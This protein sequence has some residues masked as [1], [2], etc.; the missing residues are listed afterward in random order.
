MAR[1]AREK[2]SKKF[3]WNF[4]IRLFLETCCELAV[5]A[6]LGMSYVDLEVEEGGSLAVGQVFNAVFSWASYLA[7]IVFPLWILVFF[8][9]YH[10]KINDKHFK[11]KWEAAYDG[12]NPEYTSLVY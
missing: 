1:T 7:F 5:C 8:F 9:V 12:L 4:Y 2:L 11:E 6:K 10:N 3:L